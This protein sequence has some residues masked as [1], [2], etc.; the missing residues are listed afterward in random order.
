MRPA[1]TV[2]GSNR[3]VV[4]PAGRIWEPGSSSTCSRPPSG[5]A[6]AYSAISRRRCLSGGEA[7]VGAKAPARPRVRNDNCSSTASRR[8][9]RTAS[10]VP[11][12]NKKRPIREAAVPQRQPE[13]DRQRALHP[14]APAHNS[15]CRGRC[16]GA[17]APSGRRSSG[18]T[19][20]RRRPG[21]HRRCRRQTPRLPG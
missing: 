17:S 21:C 3:C 20:A 18:A 14:Q 13:A 1:V 12:P 15:Q 9:L 10:Q 6:A 7:H 5:A 16:E 4:S 19:N 2:R 8:L 11:T